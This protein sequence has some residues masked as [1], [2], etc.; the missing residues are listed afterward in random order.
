MNHSKI[1]SSKSI[2]EA[3]KDM[4]DIATPSKILPVDYVLNENDVLCGRGLKCSEH[5]GNFRFRMIVNQS[6][7]HYTN[8]TRRPEK[9]LIITSI[10]D[11]IR[12]ASK[13]GGGFVK[14][15][16]STERYYEVGD[17]LAVRIPDFNFELISTLINSFIGK[18]EI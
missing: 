6:L 15:D 1:S 9:T 12:D 11:E 17:Y 4:N 16:P 13:S 14:Y 3:M 8:V 7:N 18:I 10:V 2:L 5:L